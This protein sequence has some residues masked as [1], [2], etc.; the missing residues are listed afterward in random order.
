MVVG[1]LATEIEEKEGQRW[2]F[3]GIEN[4]TTD[5]DA[6]VARA[7]SSAEAAERIREHAL[8]RVEVV[9]RVT[10]AEF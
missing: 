2:S 1:V 8:D 10:E 7:F 5:F 9:L 3:E 6:F 4:R